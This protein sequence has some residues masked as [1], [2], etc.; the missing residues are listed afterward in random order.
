MGKSR[1]RGDWKFIASGVAAAVWSSVARANALRIVTYNI[2]A[3]T[4]GQL[5]QMGGADA[6]P[7]LTQVLQA[8]G[9]VSLNDNGAQRAQPID[10]LALEEMNYPNGTNGNL[11]T[12][13][14]FVV[15]QLNTIYGNGTYAYDMTADPTTGNETGNG[16]SGLIYNTKTVQDLGGRAIGTP[17]GNGTSRAPMQYLL[18]PVG[19]GNATQFYLDVSHTKSGT[20]ADDATRRNVEAQE[21]VGNI[22]AGSHTIA[23]GDYNITGNSTEQTY[24]TMIGNSTSSNSAFKDVGDPSEVWSDGN[25]TAANSYIGLF[26]EK[27]TAV[28]YRD[29]IQFATPN[30]IM[31]SAQATAGMQY[32]TGSYTVFGNFGNS[33]LYNKAVTSGYNG[34]Q[35]FNGLSAN[36]SMAILGNLTTDTDHLPVVADYQVVGVAYNTPLLF[37]G[38][39]SGNGTNTTN[40]NWDLATYNFTNNSYTDPSQVVFGDTDGNGT[41]V[42]TG[43]VTI[44]SAGVTPG[45]VTF[46]N[47]N[48]AYT[49]SSSGSVGIGGNAGVL[50]SGNGTVNF[51]SPNTYSGNTTISAGTL[52]A[53]N[54]FAA[55]S[56]SA[57]GSG[58][59]TIS[60]GTFGGNGNISGAVTLS[61]GNITAGVDAVTPGKL[62]TSSTETWSGGAK[63]IWKINDATGAK[64]ASDGWD[65]LTMSALTLTSLST[66]NRFTISLNSLSGNTTGTPSHLTTSG[67]QEW[68]IAETSAATVQIDG[69]P[70][71]NVNLFGGAT[72][73]ALAGLFVLDTSGFQVSGQP[74]PNGDFSLDLVTVGGDEDLQLTYN[75]A[76]EPG[77]LILSLAGLMPLLLARRRPRY[78]G[79]V[80]R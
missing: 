51:T 27:A 4:Y 59:V 61:S 16:P 22:T 31:G 47:G 35:T 78:A 26:S 8:I 5:G 6:G 45:S 65:D 60:G 18:Q 76:P 2:D 58:S 41:P 54:G 50:L 73:V 20:T 37:S 48:L 33:T 80:E 44:Q 66:S 24:Q 63:F 23:V 49:F 56:G 67:S 15:N 43:T 38:F 21:L 70:Y 53:N 40:G 13:L 62:A 29:D 69:T 32:S 77:A 39:T 12:T 75:A 68:I 9:E 28:Q 42:S 25:Q 11:S 71:A 1:R 79:T 46:T 17:S 10:V 19:Y 72:P 57:T 74:A 7:G 52:R 30:T 64:G 36:Q 14:T 3:D 55:G 34:N